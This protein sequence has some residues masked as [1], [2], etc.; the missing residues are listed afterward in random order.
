VDPRQEL[1]RES[2]FQNLK[3]AIFIYAVL[4]MLV[5][6]SACRFKASNTGDGQ[7]F[8][9]LGAFPKGNPSWVKPAPD[10]PGVGIANA[11]LIPLQYSSPDAIQVSKSA[12]PSGISADSEQS[13]VQQA[14]VQNAIANDAATSGQGQAADS[15]LKRIEQVCPGIE[16]SINAALTTTDVKERTA[17]YELL[18]TRCPES[19]DLWIWL[20]ME[21]EHLKKMG[22]AARCYRKALIA[23]GENVEAKS[24]LEQ[25]QSKGI[26]A[27]AGA[28]IKRKSK[29][30][31]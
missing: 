25:L 5:S 7:E 22:E 3:K 27:S 20:G 31:K 19:P 2:I 9:R 13:N 30:K 24:L 12:I 28:K 1:R 6:S 4:F 29:R 10:A 23:D 26:G 18:A 14:V 21:Y 11:G 8:V 15:P 16:R 17:K